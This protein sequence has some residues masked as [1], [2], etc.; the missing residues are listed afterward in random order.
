MLRGG[1]VRRLAAEPVRGREERGAQALPLLA[2]GRQVGERVA[3]LGARL[4]LSREGRE[5]AHRPRARTAIEIGGEPR[6]EHAG[7]G[8]DALGVAELRLRLAMEH[9][10]ERLDLGTVRRRVEP[11]RARLGGAL[12]LDAVRHPEV[13]ATREEQSARAHEREREKDATARATRGRER[14]ARAVR[15]AGAR[16]GVV[17]PAVEATADA[18]GS[19]LGLVHARLRGL[20]RPNSGPA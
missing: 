4:R 5:L 8:A 12:R 16:P 11:R 20:D 13:P 19:P 14:A 17:D 7:R 2:R 1:E 10:L 3:D 9:R 6:G 15:A 18:P